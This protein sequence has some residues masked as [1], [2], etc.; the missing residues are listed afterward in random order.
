[1]IG[2]LVSRLIAAGTPPEVAAVVVAEAYAA[3][4]SV[5]RQSAEHPVDTATEN[6]R[7]YDR[8]RQR[9]IRELRRASADNPPTPQTPLTLSS[10]QQEQTIEKEGKKVRAQKR[11][12]AELSPTWQPSE[13]H[14]ETAAKMKISR[15]AVLGK[16]EDMRIWAG[17]TGAMKVDWDLTFHGFLRRDA[18]KLSSQHGK[19]NGQS[20]VLAAA[21]RLIDR[22]REFDAPAPGEQRRLCSGEGALAVRAIPEG[23]CERPGYLR[24][25]DSGD[26]VGLSAGN[27]ALRDGSADGHRGKPV[28]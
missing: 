14:F 16:A 15:D 25:V 1:M 23:G 26:P 3:G 7:A 18:S 11:K 8:E 20:S 22:I 10:S 9:K 28:G 17:S 6:R 4:M 24:G 27:D 13:V 12:S 21:D 19:S 5:C 2:D